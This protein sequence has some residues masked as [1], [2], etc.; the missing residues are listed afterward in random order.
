M[1][2]TKTLFLLYALASATAQEKTTLS[3]A[4]LFE[5][6]TAVIHLDPPAQQTDPGYTSDS[7]FQS[8]MIYAHNWFRAEHNAS[9]LTWNDSCA[10]SSQA[11]ANK[12]IWEHSVRIIITF[13][14]G[15]SSIIYLLTL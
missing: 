7:D 6:T 9:D 3:T 4:T 8:Q 15:T 13:L 1:A 12:C 5:P 2:F 11:Y 14:P 10:T